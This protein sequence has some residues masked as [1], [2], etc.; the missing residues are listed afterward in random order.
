MLQALLL[1]MCGERMLSL[2]VENVIEL[3]CISVI[4]FFQG[5]TPMFFFCL[6]QITY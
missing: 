4:S 5:L 3:T 2:S 6:G 1:Q